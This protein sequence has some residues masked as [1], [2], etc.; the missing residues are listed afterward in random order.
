MKKFVVLVLILTYANFAEAWV[1]RVQSEGS[2][3]STYV[4]DREGD[5]S[6]GTAYLSHHNVEIESNESCDNIMDRAEALFFDD[7][8]NEAVLILICDLERKTLLLQ[9]YV[10]ATDD[11]EIDE[12]EKFVSETNGIDFYGNK[13]SFSTV[14]SYEWFPRVEFFEN[15]G[16]YD[17]SL[18]WLAPSRNY[19]GIVD[20]NEFLF[21]E[22]LIWFTHQDINEFTLGLSKFF[23]KNLSETKEA[24]KNASWLFM[25]GA[26]FFH[27]EGE[28]KIER[29]L[30]LG[31]ARILGH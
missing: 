31:P 22:M 5:E 1:E 19:K 27:L 11:S 10:E 4:S 6:V 25:P 26:G 8:V 23:D 18:V 13:I 29:L 9:V 3:K 15:E 16:D 21:G 20:L 24:I 2:I 30:S 17:P 7:I 14:V 12:V 28:I